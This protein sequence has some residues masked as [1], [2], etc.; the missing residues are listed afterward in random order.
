M[1]MTLRDCLREATKISLQQDLADLERSDMASILSVDLLEDK[2]KELSR[3]MLFLPHEGV[4]LMLSKY[5]FE[6]SPADTEQLYGFENAKGR[7]RYYRRL[8]S[9][10]MG[11]RKNEQ[12]SDASLERA[13]KIVMDDY[14]RDEMG[15]ADETSKVVFFKGKRAF[16]TIRRT[17][18]IAALIAALM[19]TMLMAASADFR[20][21]V[22]AWIVETYE[23]YSVFEVK[24]SKST[25]AASPLGFTMSYLPDGAELVD[26]LE[27][28]DSAFYIY[29]L[30]DTKTLKISIYPANTR[31]YVDTEGVEIHPLQM[32][33]LE[34]YWFAKDSLHYVCFEKDGC[35]ISV[36]G[37]AGIE[38]LWKVAAGIEINN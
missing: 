25:E 18:A 19:F 22:I 12:I 14:L 27:D 8:L 34:G 17:L 3:K 30:A 11:L 2:I 16:K 1:D 6:L 28:V 33:E 7:F 35:F 32:G 13:C 23:K 38:E 36:F 5:C 15:D 26:T 31:V 29:E 37:T 4:V 10:C 9:D 24:D 20:E 21:R